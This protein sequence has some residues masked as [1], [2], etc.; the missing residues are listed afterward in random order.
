MGQK[1]MLNP[2]MEVWK[3]YKYGLD[4]WIGGVNQSTIDTFIDEVVS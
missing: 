2:L 3:K 4:K 1:V